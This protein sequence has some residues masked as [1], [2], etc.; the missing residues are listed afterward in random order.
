MLHIRRHVKALSPFLL[1]N[2]G[3]IGCNSKNNRCPAFFEDGA[4]KTDD[5]V[6]GW[7]CLVVAL[8]IL[9]ICL[10]GLVALLRSMLLGASTRIIYKATNI[11]PLLAMHYR[12][13]R[14]SARPEFFYYNISPDTAWP[15]LVSCSWNKFIH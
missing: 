9:I 13:W 14:N 2:A 15:A 6:S 1:A 5:M 11:N 10:I 3:L 4:T 8:F 12:Y 7:V